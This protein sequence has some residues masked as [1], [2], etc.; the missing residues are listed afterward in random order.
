M[1]V[2]LYSAYYGITFTLAYWVRPQLH[3]DQRPPWTDLTCLS[4]YK[5]FVGS[6]PT[7]HS[8]PGALYFYIFVKHQLHC[9]AWPSGGSDP[10]SLYLHWG[11]CHMMGS[12]SPQVLEQLFHPS[13][14]SKLNEYHLFSVIFLS[15]KTNFD[16]FFYSVL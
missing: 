13:V 10:G 1:C 14:S 16:L 9:L 8:C 5:I 4:L 15:L 3:L 2:V 12:Y 6:V 11:I 7:C